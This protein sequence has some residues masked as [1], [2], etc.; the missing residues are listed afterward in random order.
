LIKAQRAT[1]PLYAQY[2]NAGLLLEYEWVHAKLL[3][4]IQTLKIYSAQGKLVT[5]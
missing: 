2:I 1:S 3:A 5:V 4:D